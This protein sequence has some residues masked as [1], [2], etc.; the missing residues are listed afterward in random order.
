MLGVCYYPEQWEEPKWKEDAIRMSELGIKYVRIA[1]FAWSKLEPS[2]GDLQLDWL[3]RSIDTLSEEGLQVVLGTPTATP[4]IWLVNKYPSILPY[5]EN[6]KVRGFGSRRHYSFSSSDYIRESERIVEIVAKEFGNHPAVAGWQTDNEYGCHDTIL[7]WG[8]EDLK[9]FQRWLERK[10]ST[11][12]KLNQAWGNVFW[13]MEV[14]SFEEITLPHMSVTE[15]NPAARLDFFRFSSDQVVAYNKMQVEILRKNSPG[16]FITH[17]FMGFFHDFDHF[18]VGEDLDLSSWDSYPIGFVEVF[19]FTEE[20]RVKWARTSHPDV[21]PFHHDLYRGVGKGRWWVMEQQPGPVN[22]APWNPIPLKGQIRLFTWEAFAHGAEVVSYFRW[23]QA[24]FAQEQ[25]H[26]GLNLPDDSGWSQG[27][28][29]AQTVHF[30]LQQLGELPPSSL[31]KVALVFDYDSSW[32]TRTQPQG[33]DFN[34]NVL[35]FRWYTAIRRLGLDV[36]FVPPGADLSGYSLILVPTMLHV[37]DDA[38][39]SFESTKGIVLF[40]PRS[41]SKTKHM[42]IP[43]NLPPGPLSQLIPFTV[44]EVSSLRPGLEETVVG[45]E[46]IPNGKVIKWRENVEIGEGTEVL[47]TYEDEYPFFLQNDRY[48]YLTGWADESLLGSVFSFIAKKA[49]IE[50]IQLPE[51][52]RLRKR[53][54]LTFAFN[55]GEENWSIPVTATLERR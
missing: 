10:Y 28:K 4:P 41:G 3:K 51:G 43:S 7:S 23:R 53:G 16:R 45:G 35:T 40:G 44:L 46:M 22:W 29:E 39:R 33:K 55:Y 52:I 13:S 42:S 14:N 48:F 31:A 34:Y 15:V 49:E 21:A 54:Q 32:S 11:P 26:A 6:G 25:M 2:E 27:G 8:S 20:E 17:N 18:K 12:Q 37:S 36:D 1:E 5:D 38:L 9:A 19:P 47:A 30:E 24:P 50:T